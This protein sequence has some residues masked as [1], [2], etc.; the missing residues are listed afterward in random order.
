M[1]HSTTPA[2]KADIGLIMNE[3]GKLY[4]ANEQW[5]DEIITYVDNKAEETK[6]HFDVV[7]EN[8]KHDFWGIHNDK[9]S[10][11]NDQANDHE[12]RLVTIEKQL[13]I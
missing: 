7:A 13:A 10:V 11:L 1:E 6:R 5:K 8:L 12:E 4:I 2:T 3:I 9:I